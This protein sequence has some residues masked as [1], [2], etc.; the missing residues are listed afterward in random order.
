MP[1]VLQSEYIGMPQRTKPIRD[2][3]TFRPDDDVSAL[4]AIAI[5]QHNIKKSRLLNACVRH[6]LKHLAAGRKSI[7]LD[8]SDFER[9]I[10]TEAKS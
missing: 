6:A 1:G 9:R 7:V 10:F 2:V 8:G 4:L 5:G 3:E